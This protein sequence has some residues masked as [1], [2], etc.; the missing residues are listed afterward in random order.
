MTKNEATVI[1][2]W[3]LLSVGEAGVETHDCVGACTSSGAAIGSGCEGSEVSSIC[4]PVDAAEAREAATGNEVVDAAGW[5]DGE[6]ETEVRDAIEA[7]DG[8][9]G[10]RAGRADTDVI[11]CCAWCYRDMRGD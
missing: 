10:V 9:A 7:A 8:V 11:G 2:S 6:A 1:A 4:S 3:R 5:A